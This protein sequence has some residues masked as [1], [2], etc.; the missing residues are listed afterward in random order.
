MIQDIKYR[1]RLLWL[2]VLADELA[3][4]I[5]AEGLP[6]PTRLLPVPQ[7]WRRRWER[8]FNRALEVAREL[9][10]RLGLPVN[11]RILFRLRPAVP[12]T[13]LPAN[14]RALNLRRAF[15]V[16]AQVCVGEAVAIVDDVVTTGATVHELSRLLRR[17]GAKEVC[18]WSLARASF[19]EP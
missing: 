1:G 6:M 14:E 17:A 9:G 13:G 7:H 5:R 11:D 3:S 12:Q 15:G 2:L 19:R 4:R 16:R 18:V 8:G 10:R